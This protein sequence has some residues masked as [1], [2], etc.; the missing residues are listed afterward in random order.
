[1]A[2]F[3]TELPEIS[4][5]GFQVVSGEMFVHLP[6]KNEPSCTL[7]YNSVCFGKMAVVALN[8]CERIRIE[9]NTKT[10]CILIVPVTIKD[11]DGVRWVTGSKEPQ[12]RKIDCKAFTSQLFQ[13]WGFEK[14]FVYRSYGRVVTADK[15]VMLLFDFNN[16]E[17]WKSKTPVKE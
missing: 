9:V 6:R 13:A 7:W 2:Q 3:L 16:V 5:D 11:K 17:H 4:M 15:K 1:M 10:K 8:T 12:P 14:D